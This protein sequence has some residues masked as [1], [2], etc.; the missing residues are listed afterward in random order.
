M[1]LWN[2]ILGGLCVAWL[3][4]L[5][6]IGAPD[7]H[8][9]QAFWTEATAGWA[10]AVGSV[11]A[12]VALFV[13]Q[14]RDHQHQR[15]RDEASDIHALNRIGVVLGEGYRLAT[16]I[17]LVYP[18][19]ATARAERLTEWAR[20]RSQ[21]RLTVDA[22]ERL[23]A[24]LAEQFTVQLVAKSRLDRALELYELSLHDE[25]D[26]DQLLDL[27]LSVNRVHREIAGLSEPFRRLGASPPVSWSDDEQNTGELRSCARLFGQQVRLLVA[28]VA[29]HPGWANRR[30][31]T[32]V[33]LLKRRAKQ[34][35]RLRDAFPD[36]EKRE[37]AR[38]LLTQTQRIQTFVERCMEQQIDD[39]PGRNAIARLHGPAR[40]AVET[41][42]LLA[43]PE[44]PGR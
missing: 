32:H 17:T 33:K 25:F 43:G 22:L 41:I 11:A 36:T 4:C 13:A 2:Y 23:P 16:R 14:R 28:A 18:I 15:V 8:F 38:F 10:Q 24:V 5:F 12:I 19:G 3:L 30:G 21:W 20:D 27:D 6:W 34:L 37:A 44:D 29:D 9:I 35:E 7:N 40:N 26:L 39:R 1:A 31:A 42:R